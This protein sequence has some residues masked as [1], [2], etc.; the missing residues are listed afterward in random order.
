VF[1]E[2]NSV[3]VVLI[4]NGELQNV[5]ELAVLNG[6]NAALLGDEIIQFRTATLIEPGIYVLSNLLRGK[7]G[8]EWAVSSHAAGER[9]ILLDGKVEKQ[10]VS[11]NMIGLPRQYKAIT[12]GGTLSSAGSEDFIYTGVAL[13]PYSPVQVIGTRD[14]SNNLTIDWI[15]R[16]RIGGAWQDNI[17]V[18]L[19]ETAEVY[20]IDIMNGSN[21]ARTL[22]GISTPSAAYSTAQQVTDFGSVQASVTV[23]VYQMSEIIGRGYPGEATV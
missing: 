1:D 11:N 7:L 17:D 2:Q 9:F 3:T 23:K 10:A 4:G 21:V 19:N 13:K 20:E 5:T 22:V 6:A 16:T 14:D 12:F 15:R 18:P 8:T